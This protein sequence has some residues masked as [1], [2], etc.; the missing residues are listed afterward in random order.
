LRRNRTLAIAT[1]LLAAALIAA[2]LPAQEVRLRRGDSVRLDVPQRE[3][4]GR[5][6]TVDAKG[7]VN[8]PIVGAIRLEGLSLEEA[9]GVLLRALQD[10]YPSIQS[11]TIALQGEDARRVIYV[12]GQVASPGKYELGGAPSVWDAIKE[13]GG[14]TA[15]ASLD[16]VRIVRTTSD[17]STTTL[18]NLQQ[19][20]DSGNLGSLPV[21]KPGDAVIVPERAAAYTGTGAVNVFGAVVRPASYALTQEKRLVDA[22]LAAGG[23]AENARLS[24]VTIIRRV[25][26]GSA[27]TISV[28]FK[29]YLE[30]GDSRHNPPIFPNDTVN[31]PRASSFWTSIANPSFLLAIISTSA[32]IAALA[33]YSR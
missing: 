6:L 12:Q 32:T 7:D 10:V 22:I 25:A 13:A 8:L 9:R 19:A 5:I 23:P 20:L 33:I 2:D 21:L 26:E 14:A 16:G 3:D 17:G 31:I 1:L 24:K 4:L 27:M 29:R 30:T 11:I 18:V 28:D 15:A